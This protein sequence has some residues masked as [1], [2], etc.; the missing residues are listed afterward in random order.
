MG[1]WETAWGFTSS[2][3]PRAP[4]GLLHR[5]QVLPARQSQ[6]SLQHFLARRAFQLC[7][8][9]RNEYHQGM[10]CVE[11][12][13]TTQNLSIAGSC[14]INNSALLSERL[15]AAIALLCM[16]YSRA[17]VASRRLRQKQPEFVRCSFRGHRPES[18]KPSVA[19]SCLS[20]AE[21]PRH[22]VE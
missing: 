9:Q 10:K 7:R 15:Q 1:Q 11:P 19:R 3:P 17:R 2:C 22:S 18:V 21:P 6:G 14:E 13:P 4:Q 12:S 20:R 8:R 16:R 5:P